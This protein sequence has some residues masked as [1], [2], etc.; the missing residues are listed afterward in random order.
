MIIGSLLLNT[1]FFYKTSVATP[2]PA[3]W[4]RNGQ[5]P[6]QENMPRWPIQC[7][8]A[9]VFPQANLDKYDLPLPNAYLSIFGIIM[10]TM[11]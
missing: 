1:D 5:D 10:W 6:E 2:L 7:F 3:E 4:E 11:F 9:D 8:M